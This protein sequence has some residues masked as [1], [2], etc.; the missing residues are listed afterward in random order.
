[1]EYYSF[2]LSTDIVG[3]K[4]KTICHPTKC[5][6]KHHWK[7][8][9]KYLHQFVLVSGE[10]AKNTVSSSEIL[11]F[12][13][14]FDLWVI[15][16][17]QHTDKVPKTSPQR[18]TPERRGLQCWRKAEGWSFA[19]KLA[20]LKH[21]ALHFPLQTKPETT[22]PAKHGAEVRVWLSECGVNVWHGK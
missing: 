7:Q 1:M 8:P 4:A 10:L 3:K 2:T 22:V 6:A 11:L 5:W 21:V 12:I 9:I 16:C 15:S 14:W 19:N 20:P 17:I 18:R 13:I